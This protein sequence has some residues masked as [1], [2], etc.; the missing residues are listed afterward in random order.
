MAFNA[1][2]VSDLPPL[3]TYTL[4]VRPPLVSSIPDNILSL[5]L[6]IVA[7]WGMSMIYHFI[8]VNNYFEQYRLHTPAE[9]AKRNRV[10]RWEVVRDVVL[11]QVVQTMAG[12]AMGY[13]DPVE[14]VGK[15]DY[16]VAVWAQRLR[17]AQKA[18]P[19][20]LALVGLDATGLAKSFSQ[21]GHTLLAGAVAGGSYP[22]V[23]QSLVLETGEEVMAPAFTSWEMTVASFIYWYLIPALQFALAISIVDTWQYFWH[24]AMHLNRWLYGK[25]STV[26]THDSHCTNILS[27]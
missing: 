2:V 23:L 8:D 10:T 9:L 16:D 21:N 11:Q 27:Q 4:S 24:R 19:H 12:M 22:N 13:F 18:V 14:T 25:F 7:Y 17:I 20:V 5:I 15:E 26:R 1:S 3:P 6:P